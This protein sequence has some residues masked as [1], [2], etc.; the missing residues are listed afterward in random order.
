MSLKIPDAESPNLQSD[1]PQG[2]SSDESNHPIFAKWHLLEL[3]IVALL[4][5]HLPYA[6]LS[7]VHRGKR[8]HSDNNPVTVLVSASKSTQVIWSQITSEIT[9]VLADFSLS[10]EEIA[11]VLTDDRYSDTS[12]PDPFGQIL[13]IDEFDYQS[14]MGVSLGLAGPESLDAS[15]TIG[16]QILIERPD[17]TFRLFVSAFHPFLNV[18]KER[19]Y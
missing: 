19:T 13:S 12:P 1:D 3:E 9:K 5:S 18:V 17:K 14:P 10:Q 8:L 11:V 6:M 2:C 15:A 16:G 4:L 7:L